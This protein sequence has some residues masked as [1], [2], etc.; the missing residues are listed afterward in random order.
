MH[1]GFTHVGHDGFG[2]GTVRSVDEAVDP[3]DAYDG[4]DGPRPLGGDLQEA[5]VVDDGAL[6]GAGREPL[7]VKGRQSGEHRETDS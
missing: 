7:G 2:R 4:I 6:A 1:H 3:E 5:P